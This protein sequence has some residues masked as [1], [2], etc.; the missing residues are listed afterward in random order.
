MLLFFATHMAGPLLMPRQFRP[1]HLVSPRRDVRAPE[2][3]HP[4]GGNQSRTV[5]KLGVLPPR[6]LRTF[7]EPVRRI[8]QDARL[9]LVS[10]LADAPPQI[11]NG[12]IGDPLG[13]L[14]GAGLGS[15]REGIG[16]GCCG[17]VGD[18]DGGGFASRGHSGI[19]PPTLVYKVEP[20]FSEEARRAK[21][22]GT[23]LLRVEIG[24][25]GRPR[26]MVVVETPGLGLDGKA[27]EAVA[28]WRF[29]PAMRAGKA[30]ATT[31]MIELHFHL[32]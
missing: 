3:F 28:Q 29:H 2:K 23:V 15:G 12:D 24:A 27:L 26:D 19:T 22:Q 5:A 25:D 13:R 10:T 14:G 31:A 30:V 8:N 11:G 16:I 21:Y 20:E 32:M 9:V 18:D 6:A 17:G 1:I 7:I 4:G